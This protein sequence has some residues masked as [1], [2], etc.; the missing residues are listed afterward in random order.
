M[1]SRCQV[2]PGRVVVCLDTYSRTLQVLSS[3]SSSGAETRGP[4]FTQTLLQVSRTP[5]MPGCNFS[6]F[7]L[8]SDFSTSTHVKIMCKIA[9]MEHISYDCLVDSDFQKKYLY[10]FQC[11]TLNACPSANGRNF[12]PRAELFLEN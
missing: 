7:S 11:S 4:T 9:I 6:D 10:C 2:T 3:G 5:G 1:F 8:V 12:V